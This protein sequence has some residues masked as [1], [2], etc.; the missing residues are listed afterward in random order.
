MG[1]IV[2][3]GTERTGTTTIQ[4]FLQCREVIT[5]LG[6]RSDLTSS[7]S[8]TMLLNGDSTVFSE[9]VCAREAR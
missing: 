6:N 9:V 4:E 2:H 8:S 7:T 5:Y 1:I 3:I